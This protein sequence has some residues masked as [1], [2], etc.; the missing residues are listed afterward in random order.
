[1]AQLNLYTPQKGDKIT[2]IDRPYYTMHD[3][4]FNIR[5]RVNHTRCNNEKYATLE[6]AEKRYH[7]L[8][9]A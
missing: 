4:Q 3:K 9:Q 1:M 8:K 7:Q 6:Q 2:Y 5:Y